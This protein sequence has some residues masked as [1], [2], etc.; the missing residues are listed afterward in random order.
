MIEPE[1]QPTPS[2]PPTPPFQFSLRTLLLLC[3]VLGSSLAVFGGW[4]IVVFALAVVVALDIR[5]AESL[6]SPS[7]ITFVAF[8]LIGFLVVLLMPFVNV[9]REANRR[10]G[11]ENNLRQ[12]AL[13]LQSYHQANGCFPPAHIVDKNGEPIH[14]WRLLILPYLNYG[15][16]HNPYEFGEPWDG[17]MNKLLLQR[18]GDY[19][20]PSEPNAYEP[21]ANQTSY[22]AVT[23]PNT[24]WAGEKTRKLA[25]FGKDASS[26]IMLI[27]VANSG[28]AYAEPRDFSL[29]TLNVSGSN[30]PPMPLTSHRVGHVEFFVIYDGGSGVHVAMADRSVHFLQTDHL[31]P[32][33]LR[34]VL[35]IGG[36]KNV[37]G[38]PHIVLDEGDWRLNWPN[39]AALLVWLL[40][41]G[42]LLVGAVRSRK[43]TSV[44]PTPAG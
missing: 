13:A 2:P 1:P 44:V 25:D 17:P 33:D 29:E 31:S 26:T 19:V 9:A 11:C 24:A 12:I 18:L 6:S 27:E 3:V 36:C 41:V 14:S 7:F 35:T 23:G 22:V 43:R 16:P 30:S 28:I 21:G 38:G 5:L 34:K 42:T 20:C 15:V 4:G 40:S 8:C 32:E 10:L 39:I 37:A